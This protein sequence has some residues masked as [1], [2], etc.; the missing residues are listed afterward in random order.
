MTAHHPADEEQSL[1]AKMSADVDAPGGI[2]IP[3][4]KLTAFP[5]VTC[6]PFGLPVEPEV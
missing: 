3:A 1:R 2:T 6:T 4:K 5:C